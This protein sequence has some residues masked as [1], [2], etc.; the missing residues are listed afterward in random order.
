MRSRR[1]EGR[2]PRP[3]G[4]APHK[5]ILLLLVLPGLIAAVRLVLA[6]VES[7]GSWPLS[8]WLVIG[9]G[10]AFGLGQWLVSCYLYLNL[11]LRPAQQAPDGL[12]VDVLV[13]A[14]EESLA[15]VETTLRAAC[16]IR[17]PHA[18][19]LVDERQRRELPELA[20]RLGAGYLDCPDE[21][22]SPTRGEFMA[23]F[24]ARHA[25]RPDFLERTLGLFNDRRVGF[26]QAM[27]AFSNVEESRLAGAAAQVSCEADNVS[28]VATDDCGAASL[29]E[30]RAVFRR[31]ALVSTEGWRGGAG[32]MGNLGASLSLHAQ[33]WTS[34]YV[35]EPLV[36]STVPADLASFARQQFAWS[37]GLIEAALASLR[38][39]FFRLRPAQQLCYGLRFSHG[40]VGAVILLNLGFLAASLVCSELS[41]EDMLWPWIPPVLSLVAVRAYALR[42]ASGAHMPRGLEWNG[43]CLVIASWPVY[44]FAFVTGVLRI[45][46]PSR[47]S[48][49]L[50]G[51]VLSGALLPSQVLMVCI[52][53]SAVGWRLVHWAEAPM[54]LTLALGVVA[55]GAHWI[56]VSVWLQGRQRVAAGRDRVAVESAAG[57]SN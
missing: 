11:R 4:A 40:F 37:R 28:A 41:T 34:A 31:S 24:D 55:I 22:L 26:V 29:M 43:T 33:G 44:V 14:G 2:V 15:V 30:R 10:L 16:G 19:Y 36:E 9:A 6:W 50:S 17:Y 52:L 42:S 48:S 5:G 18:T 8:F 51:S 12:S 53:F 49:R 3:S 35:C 54:P 13:C 23:V 25:P 38:G 7:R 27:H 32:G 47:A 21:T 45:R 57:V 20:A 46:V 39:P 1:S 56:L